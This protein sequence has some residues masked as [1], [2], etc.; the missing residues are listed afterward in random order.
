MNYKPKHILKRTYGQLILHECNVV[1]GYKV[2]I[3]LSVRCDEGLRQKNLV[4]LQNKTIINLKVKTCRTLWSS[5]YEPFSP[6]FP[7]I[8]VL[9]RSSGEELQDRGRGP[10][11]AHHHG[12]ERQDED[13]REEQARDLRGD[14]E[15]VQCHQDGSCPAHEEHQAE[16][17]GRH[18]QVVGQDQHQQYVQ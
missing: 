18:L 2:G 1:T 12:Y 9:F 17:P 13:P 11:A 14:P 4:N 6:L 8:L 16:R 10:D 3:T 15:A 5:S 7:P